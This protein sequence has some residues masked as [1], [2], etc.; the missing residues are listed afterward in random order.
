MEEVFQDSLFE[1]DTYVK[2][3]NDAVDKLV[4]SVN[5]RTWALKPEYHD[6]FIVNLQEIFESVSYLQGIYLTETVGVKLIV[7]D[8]KLF[9]V[10]LTDD[11]DYSDDEGYV[12][13]SFF[14]AVG[15]KPPSYDNDYD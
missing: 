14:D 9:V 7:H 8:Q 10:F 13:A 15:M 5:G 1:G 2:L 6:R 12:A 11:D 4:E 3:N